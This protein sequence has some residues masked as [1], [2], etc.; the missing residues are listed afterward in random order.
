MADA[1]VRQ[2]IPTEYDPIDSQNNLF[3]RLTGNAEDTYTVHPVTVAA[4]SLGIATVTENPTTGVENFV[5]HQRRR[6]IGSAL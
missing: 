1:S 2:W 6:R 4:D 5:L 3:R